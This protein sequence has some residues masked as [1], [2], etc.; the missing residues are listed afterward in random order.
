MSGIVGKPGS[1]SGILGDNGGIG[2][3]EG[4]FTFSLKGTSG[5]AGSWAQ[6]SQTGYYRKIGST[7]YF[8]CVCYLTNTGSYSGYAVVEGLPFTAIAEQFAITL[9]GFPND[10]ASDFAA[11]ITANSNQVV[12]RKGNKLD[13]AVD[14]SEITTGYRMVITG[15]Y[16]TS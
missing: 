9:A 5:S 12:F 16:F 3:E 15:F 1:K 7:V 14:Y 4:T 11:R 6:S 10:S 2:Y 8:D 13:F